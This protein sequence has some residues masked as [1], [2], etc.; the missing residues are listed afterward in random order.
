MGVCW[1]C[2]R[3]SLSFGWWMRRWFPTCTVS[4]SRWTGRSPLSR[5]LAT[6]WSADREFR[7]SGL[8]AVKRVSWP[9]PSG[10]SPF[11]WTLRILSSSLWLDTWEEPG[12]STCRLSEVAPCC[13]LQ[14][15][16]SSQSFAEEKIRHND[17]F[18]TSFAQKETGK[19]YLDVIKTQRV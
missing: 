9:S 4:S 13:V 17:C 1:S 8:D 18:D 2:T 16:K 15:P 14:S 5:L 19:M 6:L 12:A 7:A 3:G 11:P 10:P